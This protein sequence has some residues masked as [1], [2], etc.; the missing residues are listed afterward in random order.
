MSVAA[1]CFHVV[2][3]FTGFRFT[4]EPS[5]EQVVSLRRHA[6]GARFVFNQCLALVKTALDAQATDRQ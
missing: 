2:G 5:V 1:R 6:G 4:L 3:R